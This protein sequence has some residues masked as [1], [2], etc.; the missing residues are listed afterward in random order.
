LRGRRRGGG[1]PF[2]SSRSTTQH[3]RTGGPPTQFSERT[4]GLATVCGNGQNRACFPLEEPAL[5]TT[6]VAAIL[7]AGF[8]TAAPLPPPQT[9][10]GLM[11]VTVPAW[12]VAIKREIVLCEEH[13][14]LFSGR[15]KKLDKMVAEVLMQP[16]P[17]LDE[18]DRVIRTRDFMLMHRIQCLNRAAAY[19]KKLADLAHWK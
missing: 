5:G 15:V 13:A 19:R 6:L 8:A 4:R 12:K 11:R 16:T 10:P 18:L 3:P 1:Y 2:L 9:Y 7:S 14:D 17:D